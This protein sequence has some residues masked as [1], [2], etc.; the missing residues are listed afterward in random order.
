[1]GSVHE[2]AK[3]IFITK[4]IKGKSNF[5][6]ILEIKNFIKL[7]TTWKIGAY[8]TTFEVKPNK[9]RDLKRNLKLF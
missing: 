3:A 2:L 5:L 8:K 9:F 6:E 4:K 1:V 7:F